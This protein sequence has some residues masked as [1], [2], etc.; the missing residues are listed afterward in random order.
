MS[1]I[2]S[3]FSGLKAEFEWLIASLAVASGNTDGAAAADTP[4]A[5]A[6]EHRGDSAPDKHTEIQTLTAERSDRTDHPGPQHASSDDTQSPIS[7]THVTDVATQGPINLLFNADFIVD[8]T[9]HSGP[10]SSP[11][12]TPISFEQSASDLS[13]ISA[14]VGALATPV[15]DFHVSLP[16]TD[17]IIGMS[18]PHPDAGEFAL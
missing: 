18:R 5:D 14:V 10:I 4:T 12:L 9:H 11:G 16:E 13:A 17:T 7:D 2:A 3:F 15:Q 6:T 8:T 1:F